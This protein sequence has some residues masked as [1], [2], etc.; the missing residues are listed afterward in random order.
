L[1]IIP[2]PFQP[3]IRNSVVHYE[4]NSTDEIQNEHPFLMISRIFLPL[5]I[6]ILKNGI[7]PAVPFIMI[8][9]MIDVEALC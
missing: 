8:E 5:K 6:S 9:E 4:H 2:F 3:F 1:S 7:R